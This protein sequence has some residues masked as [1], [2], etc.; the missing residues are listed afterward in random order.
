MPRTP[1]EVAKAALATTTQPLSLP[2]R[3]MERTR[4]REFL[5]SALHSGAL[6]LKHPTPPSADLI[7][8]PAALRSVFA[9]LPHPFVT[10]ALHSTLW[11]ANEEVLRIHQ[12]VASS[13]AVHVVLLLLMHHSQCLFTAWERLAA[14][15]PVHAAEGDRGRAMFIG[16]KPGTGKTASVVDVVRDMKRKAEEGAVPRFQFLDLNGLRLPTP[17][18]AYVRLHE[19]AAGQQQEKDQSRQP[20]ASRDGAS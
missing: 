18:H 5:Q 20:A 7:E 9:A 6:P 1:L 10:A 15:N 16:G 8:Y 14:G 4:I 2:C 17:K 19:C 12:F 3:D 13:I 11:S